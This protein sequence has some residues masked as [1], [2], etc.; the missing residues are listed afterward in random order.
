MA[1]N[2][3][4]ERRP[5]P[6]K[7]FKQIERNIPQP[8]NETR[9]ATEQELYD[10]GFVTRSISK[11]GVECIWRQGEKV[12]CYEDV[13]EYETQNENKMDSPEKNMDGGNN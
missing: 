7:E 2:I 13:G 11:D 6:K 4:I 5:L 1:L 8:L 9:S 3:K 12:V 10:A